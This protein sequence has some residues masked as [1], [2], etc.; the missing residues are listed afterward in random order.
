VAAGCCT[1]RFLEQVKLEL[2]VD[3]LVIPGRIEAR[4]LAPKH[5]ALLSLAKAFSVLE[6]SPYDV[7]FDSCL[8]SQLIKFL[9]CSFSGIPRDLNSLDCCRRGLG[10]P[11][12]VF[13]RD[14][15]RPASYDNGIKI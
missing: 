3:E 4:T 15:Q 13:K 12:E 9:R 1:S 2:D 6:A 11:M 14:P 7:E 8:P 10:G 5:V